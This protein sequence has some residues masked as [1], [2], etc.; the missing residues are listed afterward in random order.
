MK[1]KEQVILT[2]I[3]FCLQPYFK[4]VNMKKKGQ[5]IKTWSKKNIV[6]DDCEM[7]LNQPQTTFNS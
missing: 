7:V 6:M 5:R 4:K 2:K 1:K 3:H